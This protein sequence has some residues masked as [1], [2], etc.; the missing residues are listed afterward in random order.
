MIDYVHIKNK[1][2]EKMLLA[3]KSQKYIEIFSRKKSNFWIRKNNSNLREK[4]KD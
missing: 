2:G 1:V 4:F 3:D